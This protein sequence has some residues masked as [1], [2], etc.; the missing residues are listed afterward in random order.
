MRK[1]NVDDMFLLSEIA[2][3]MEVELPEYPELKKSATKDE[4]EKAQKLYGTKILTLLVRKIYKAK[5]EII[6]LIENVTE[7]DV[8]NMGVKEITSTFKELLTQ[9]GVLSFFK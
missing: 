9:D 7:K 8:K 3:K 5:D 1:L 4:I 2:D 6:R